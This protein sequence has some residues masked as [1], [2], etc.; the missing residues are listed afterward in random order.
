[1]DKI[2]KHSAADIGA[3]TDSNHRNS[4]SYIRELYALVFKYFPDIQD[5]S[6]ADTNQIGR[7]GGS[8]HPLFHQIWGD[9]NVSQLYEL[10]SFAKHHFSKNG[11]QVYP[12]ELKDLDAH[13]KA[14]I[15]SAIRSLK[16]LQSSANQVSGYDH[17]L[18]KGFYSKNLTS[19]EI[20]QIQECFEKMLDSISD[21]QSSLL[22]MRSLI[23]IYTPRTLHET[24]D[25]TR[26]LR[27]VVDSPPKPRPNL[28]HPAWQDGARDVYL[29]I[30]KVAAF[31]MQFPDL[32]QRFRRRALSRNI[33]ALYES[34]LNQKNDFFKFFDKN[35]EHVKHKLAFV[36]RGEVPKKR[37][38]ILAELKRLMPVWSLYNEIAW[39]KTFGIELFGALWEGVDSDVMAL[40]MTADWA[41]HMIHFN[42]A[43]FSHVD[44]EALRK[45]APLSDLKENIIQLDQ[46]RK[47]INRELER[48][49]NLC[50][51][52]ENSSWMDEESH[53]PLQE[54]KQNIQNRI[55]HISEL[56][57]WSR[58]MQRKKRCNQNMAK[59]FVQALENG[60]IAPDDLVA[61]F[62]LNLT[63]ATFGGKR[64]G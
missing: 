5:N 34:V 40:R 41:T 17:R 60:S 19:A 62:I 49:G 21:L 44:I 31:H 30:D 39:S 55:E 56:T 29:L 14:D 46:T 48:L 45:Q 16:D 32:E 35:R 2:E 50:H 6:I 47:K 43:P 27:L 26:F 13:S 58:F 28:A 18:W 37:Q 15:L 54:L 1:M 25:W 7:N 4:T 42:R 11:G 52:S 24:G 61:N 3:N 33:R 63:R 53:L 12:V 10:L 38:D 9:W 51:T 22:Q 23:P 20:G 57:E 8:H 64:N 59:P 36:F